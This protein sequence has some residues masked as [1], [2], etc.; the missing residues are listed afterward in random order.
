MLC[1]APDTFPPLRRD[2]IY[3]SQYCVPLPPG[4]SDAVALLRKHSPMQ[5]LELPPAEAI[6]GFARLG[7]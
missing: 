4:F 3:S 7:S 5:V 6:Y 1:T 2:E